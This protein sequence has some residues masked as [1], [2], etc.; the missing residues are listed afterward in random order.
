MSHTPFTRSALAVAMTCLLLPAA[1]ADQDSER[2]AL[3]RIAYE[4]QRL[5]VQVT[6]AARE[7]PGGQ[8][9]RFRYDW[10][11][12]DVSL[13]KQGIH[14]HLDAPQQPRPVPLLKGDYRQ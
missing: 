6:E 8:R 3:A 2:E 5:E 9:I 7:A 13:I 1:H 11:L 14:E 10:L 12:R 4:L